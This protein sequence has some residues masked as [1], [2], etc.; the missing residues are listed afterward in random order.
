[1]LNFVSH[2]CYF[3]EKTSLA[4]QPLNKLAFAIGLTEMGADCLRSNVSEVS[5][6]LLKHRW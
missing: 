4:T 5:A 3:I 2:V 6:Y 1:M